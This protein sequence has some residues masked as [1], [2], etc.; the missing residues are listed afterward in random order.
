MLQDTFIQKHGRGEIGTTVNDAVADGSQFEIL[1]LWQ[2]RTRKVNGCRQ[3]RNLCGR[4]RP[5]RQRSMVR[6]GG[7]ETWRR[8]HS[9]DLSL[10]QMLEPAADPE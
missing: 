5:I 3:I 10:Y 2:P 8:S 9:I 1:H 4:I 7:A 6:A